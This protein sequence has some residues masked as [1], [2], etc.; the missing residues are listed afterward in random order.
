VF[1][2]SIS[3]IN[4][5]FINYYHNW[6]IILLSIAPA[7]PF[8]GTLRGCSCG[9]LDDEVMYCHLVDDA[10][11]DVSCQLNELRG[12]ESSASTYH[13]I[14]RLLVYCYSNSIVRNF[15]SWLSCIVMIGMISSTNISL[16]SSCY[17]YARGTKHRYIIAKLPAWHS[18]RIFNLNACVGYFNA[19]ALNY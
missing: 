16:A 1:Y 6:E 19:C 17:F 3:V 14:D 13:Y 12:W 5:A 7:G 8:R 4:K 2:R 9:G 10:K 11:D 15:F 18:Q